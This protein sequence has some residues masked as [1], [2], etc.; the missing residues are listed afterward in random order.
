MKLAERGLGW[1]FWLCFV[2]TS[3]IKTFIQIERPAAYFGIATK[4]S[5][6]RVG[7]G[8]EALEEGLVL[9]ASSFPFF[10]P[11]CLESSYLTGVEKQIKNIHGGHDFSGIC[12][13]CS[14]AGIEISPPQAVSAQPIPVA[15]LPF[16]FFF[17][18][19]FS[20]G[21]NG[22]RGRTRQDTQLL[23]GHVPPEAQPWQ[24]GFGVPRR[25]PCRC[26]RGWNCRCRSVQGLQPTLPAGSFT[27]RPAVT[28]QLLCHVQDL[29]FKCHSLSTEISLAFSLLF[30]S[31]SSPICDFPAFTSLDAPVA[32][33]SE[34]ASLKLK[35]LYLHT[36]VAIACW[37]VSH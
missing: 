33:R 29:A 6:D 27:L 3:L 11:K 12:W 2:K 13:K 37:G 35:Y 7:V 31:T 30:P 25:G 17:F 20:F 19:M 18:N 22:Q 14:L 23:F 21:P 9:L 28:L 8:R 4:G 24:D 10:S 34:V 1:L 16:F 26:S 32:S 15:F 5:R 36:Q